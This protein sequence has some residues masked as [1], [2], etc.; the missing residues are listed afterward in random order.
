MNIKDGWLNVYKPIG[1]TSSKTVIRIKNKFKL[2]KIGHAGTI[3]PMA[4][5]I[6]PIA[7]GYTTKIIS[8]LDNKRKKYEFAIKWGQQ[9]TTDDSEGQIIYSN[10]KT[11]NKN[12]IM[13]NLKLYVGKISQTPPKYSAVKF[14]GERAYDLSRK[15]INFELQSKNVDVFSL[16]F[17][18]NLSKNESIFVV[19]CGK[20]FYVRSFA[21]DLGISLGTRA[22][23]LRIKRQ[24]VGIFNEKN[25]ILLDDLLK[26]RHLSSEINGYFHSIDV[27]DDIP[28]LRVNDEQILNIRMGK[29][30]EISFLE[31]KIL[32]KIESKKLIYASKGN[33][34]IALG[35]VEN[36]FFK[37][38]KV[39]K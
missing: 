2:S 36:N 28:A 10:P 27:L 23:I 24:E 7:I 20:G 3:D 30:I 16:K 35:I 33:Q 9:T 29:K 13:K 34:V 4:E 18:K 31:L 38:K 12:E 25:A 15:K 1:I 5:G 37:P 8:F 11:P 26:I 17:I 32:K 19:E 39:F 21:R 6:L 14:K 22:H